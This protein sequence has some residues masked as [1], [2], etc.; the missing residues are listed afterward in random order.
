MAPAADAAILTQVALMV[1]V[2]G[3]NG[4]SG[5]S[6][7]SGTSAAGAEPEQVVVALGS[8]LGSDLG[9]ARSH[10]AWAIQSLRGLQPTLGLQL[11]AV[12]PLYRSA[13][14][15]TEGPDFLNAVV[16]L[17]GPSDALSPLELLNALQALE[18]S[19]GRQRPYRYA[20]RTLDL[21]II[22]FGH[23]VIDHARLQVPHPRALE[24][25]FV[26]QPLLDILPDLHWPGLGGAWQ[27]C[28]RR[29]QSP[30]P[31]RVEGADWPSRQPD[32]YT[33]KIASKNF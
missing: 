22:L 24:R 13:P 27:Q 23:R 15:Q 8:N 3:A 1:D 11:V 14:W 10:L 31:V 33:P 16:A 12:S 7:V 6:G 17:E 9:D 19:R 2:N 30:L 5:M 28:L 20:P 29:V 4:V 21:D 25:A 32:R 18:L 26:L